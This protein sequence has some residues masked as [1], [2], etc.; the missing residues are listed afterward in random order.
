MQPGA[1]DKAA[2]VLGR[3]ARAVDDLADAPERWPESLDHPGRRERVVEGHTIVYRLRSRSANVAEA[4]VV[5]LRVFGPRRH[6][7]IL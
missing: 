3:I 5:V 1:G 6:R 4:E 7:A 2:L